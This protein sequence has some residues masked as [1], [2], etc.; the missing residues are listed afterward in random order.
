MN[1]NNLSR[2]VC[3]IALMFSSLAALF[4]PSGVAQAAANLVLN[5]GF[6]T[7]GITPAD[8]ANWVDRKSVV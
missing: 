4:S 1:K 8:A 6:E 7:A 3:S 5:P 2:I